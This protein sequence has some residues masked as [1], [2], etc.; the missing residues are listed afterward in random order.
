[1]TVIP[2]VAWLATEVDGEPDGDDGSIMEV[3]YAP[4]EASARRRAND[5]AGR[6]YSGEGIDEHIKVQRRPMLDGFAARGEPTMAGL[7]ADG[8]VLKCRE[9]DREIR[10]DALDYR[11]ADG[12]YDGTGDYDDERFPL[13]PS[14]S[15]VTDDNVWCGAACLDAWETRWSWRK[16]IVSFAAAALP[17]GVLDLYEWQSSADGRW[18]VSWRDPRAA[19][20]ATVVIG[21]LGGECGMLDIDV[22]I[23]QFSALQGTDPGGSSVDMPRRIDKAIMGALR[24]L[25]EVLAIRVCEA[26]G[27]QARYDI[28]AS[29]RDGDRLSFIANAVGRGG[30]WRMQ[31]IRGEP[32]CGAWST[33]EP[34]DA[35]YMRHV[36]SAPFCAWKRREPPRVGAVAARRLRS[37][38]VSAI[39]RHA[40]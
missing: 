5:K 23:P 19:M 36:Y 11:D 16:A 9:C 21:E 12:G 3:V 31:V 4:C 14:E 30:T 38:W 27:F 35:P 10:D 25:P 20:S 33:V 29:G 6:P 32:G 1:M 28:L 13:L 17:A 26:P 24:D 40:T 8:W 2:D 22:Y 34:G 15:V 18:R 37:R 39:V 7:L